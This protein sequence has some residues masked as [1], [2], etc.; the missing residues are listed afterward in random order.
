MNSQALDFIFCYDRFKILAK[1]FCNQDK[2]EGGERVSLSKSTRRGEVGGRGSIG[3][4]RKEGI[5]S[6]GKN[7][8]DPRGGKAKGTK[9]M[10][11]ILTT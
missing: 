5:G 4:D 10:M 3:Q 2:E 9:S 6:E 1:T 11:D 8:F 7:P